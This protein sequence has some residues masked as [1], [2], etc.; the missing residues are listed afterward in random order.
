MLDCGLR[1]RATITYPFR[2][3]LLRADCVK[4]PRRSPTMPTFFALSAHKI[5]SSIRIRPADPILRP[6]KSCPTFVQKQDEE[7]RAFSPC[8]G[9]AG[10]RPYAPGLL[11][12]AGAKI[13]NIYELVQTGGGTGQQYGRQVCRAVQCARK[14]WRCGDPVS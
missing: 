8:K 7:I 1:D 4:K 3:V 9:L 10:E 12:G 13:R 2:L 6:L 5:T 14:F 11:P